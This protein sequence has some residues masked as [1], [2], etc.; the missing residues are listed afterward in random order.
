MNAESFP[1]GEALRAALAVP[2]AERLEAI[3]VRLGQGRHHTPALARITQAEGLVGDRWLSDPRRERQLTLMDARVIRMLLA[4][5]PEH[6]A[7][8]GALLTDEPL[9]APGD[10]LVVDMPTSEAVLPPGTRI[11]IGQ[12]LIETNAVPHL[13]CKKFEA[14]FGSDALAWVNAKDEL[15]LH[16]R[17]IHATV[18]EDGEVRVGDAL[19]VV[20]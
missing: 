5:R 3:V 10:N 9:H 16:L 17:G 4:R 2:R 15:D 14:R 12:A 1:T 13:G 8:Q 11:R 18:I 6:D 7:A 20:A 19:R